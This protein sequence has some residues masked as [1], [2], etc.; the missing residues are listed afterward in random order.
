MKRRSYLLYGFFLIFWSACT[1]PAP[2]ALLDWPCEADDQCS[3]GL[4]CCPVPSSP[5]KKVC[6]EECIQCTP[7]EERKCYP[8]QY[9]DNAGV[10]ECKYGKQLCLDDGTWALECQRAVLPVKEVCDAK[11][12]DCDGK[13][14]EGLPKC[15]CA[16]VGQKRKCYSGD[17]KTKGVGVCKEGMQTCQSNHR[18]GQCLGE[19]LPGKEE[20][21]NK[22]NDC[23]GKVDEDLKKSCSGKCSNK[24][25]TECVAGR[26]TRCTAEPKPEECNGKDDDCDGHIDN[27]PNSTAPLRK[28]CPYSGPKGTKDVGICRAGVRVCQK[29]SWGECKGEV[30]PQPKDCTNGKDNDCDGK[31]DVNCVCPSSCVTDRDCQVKEC[32]ARRTCV[33]G[34]CKE[35]KCPDSCL[36]DSDC[37]A[38][39][40]RARTRCIDS[41]CTSID[42]PKTCIDDS[43]CKVQACGEKQRCEKGVCVVPDC[44]K[45]CSKDEECA[46]STCGNRKKCYNNQCVEACPSSCKTSSDCA[47]VACGSKTYC[48]LGHCHTPVCPSRCSSNSDCATSACGSRQRC[49]A[50]HCVDPNSCPSSCSSSSQCAVP[51]CGSRTTCIKGK[52]ASSVCPSTC[53]SDNDCSAAGCGSRTSCWITNFQRTCRDLRSCP[54]SCKRDDDCDYLPCGNKII[55]VNGKCAEPTTCPSSCVSSNNCFTS[56]CKDKVACVSG[57]CAKPSTDVYRRCGGGG[58][59]SCPSGYV[60]INTTFQSFQRKFRCL[61]DCS[62]TGKCDSGYQCL[63]E[64]GLAAASGSRGCF[65]LCNGVGS[66]CTAI[67]SIL[68][69]SPSRSVCL[70]R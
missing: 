35:V 52:C 33:G 50:G 24:G 63:Y 57:K 7:G 69:C 41:K 51:G 70:D 6:M 38:D 39:R 48:Y 53:Q 62:A 55:C 12:N 8:E 61:K 1:L 36:T 5:N 29:G 34:V 43:D 58:Q 59:P 37:P 15:E 26:W 4:R 21:D 25:T 20:C 17:K 18:W 60:C 27:I 23:D 28:E 65:K 16:P 31:I 2:P 64:H 68:Y 44:P 66:L 49:V 19:V 56:Q 10:G 32:G 46:F 14:D 42:C 67:D 40:C 11:D 22:D 54:S 45:S 47:K 30:L 9:A 13:I 3:E